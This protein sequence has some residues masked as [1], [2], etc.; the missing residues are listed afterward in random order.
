VASWELLYYCSDCPYYG[1]HKDFQIE[2]ELKPELHLP[3]GF[4]SCK[5]FSFNIFTSS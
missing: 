4:T 5:V 1:G 2:P 3:M